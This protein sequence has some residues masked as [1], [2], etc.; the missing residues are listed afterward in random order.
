M[1]ETSNQLT[2]PGFTENYGWCVGIR[3]WRHRYV[4][5]SKYTSFIQLI[6]LNMVSL[7]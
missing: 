3:N 2:V 1:Q 4:R 5:M 6:N 7:S